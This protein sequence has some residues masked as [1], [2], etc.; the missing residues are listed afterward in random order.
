MI[1]F[2]FRFPDLIYKLSNT[3]QSMWIAIGWCNYTTINGFH[4][5]KL[6]DSERFIKANN[7][8]PYKL[9]HLVENFNTNNNNNAIWKSKINNVLEYLSRG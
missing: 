8:I 3:E 1:Y 4:I 6:K 5:F 7:F 9:S 2:N